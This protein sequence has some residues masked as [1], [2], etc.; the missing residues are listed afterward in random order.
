MKSSAGTRVRPQL[1]VRLG[2]EKLDIITRWIWR[3][4]GVVCRILDVRGGVMPERVRSQLQH[5]SPPDP[6]ST[7]SFWSLGKK[8][9][10]ALLAKLPP[11][12]P[13]DIGG[14]R[15]YEGTMTGIQLVDSR[16]SH[17]PETIYMSYDVEYSNGVKSEGNH[18]FQVAEL[19]GILQEMNTQLHGKVNQYV[20]EW[21]AETY[22]GGEINR[23]KWKAEKT[24]VFISYRSRA[25]GVAEQL[26][27]YLG[28]YENRTLFL[29]RI[30][31][32]D[33]QA[34]NWLDQLMQMIERCV[35]FIPILS[36][37]YLDG[38]ISKPELDQALREHFYGGEKRIIPV[39]I[40][41]APD[42]YSGHFVGGFQMVKAVEGI[43]PETL[44]EI[45]Y[46][47]LGLSRN[48]YEAS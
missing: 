16:S 2:M 30:D 29:P 33:L 10:D 12:A 38:P 19:P 6:P 22:G 44:E 14:S 40:E 8:L 11:I 48:P 5:S 28:E 37:D 23:E 36:K 47:A 15:E 27:E 18:T 34:G 42:D 43:T 41:G 32:V 20:K 4:N 1:S 24:E 45:V 13:I 35:V 9:V 26:F 7:S 3:P 46:L 39:L 17:S 25:S 21:F 31:L